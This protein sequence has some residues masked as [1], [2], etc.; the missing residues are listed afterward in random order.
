M[1][2]NEQF[3]W[4][5]VTTPSD[6]ETRRHCCCSNSHKDVPQVAVRNVSMVAFTR[7]KSL[8]SMT[9]P[10]RVS[11]L[12]L[13]L[14]HSEWPKLYGVLAVLSAIGLCT[15]GQTILSCLNM[16]MKLIAL[17]MA[18]TLW[19]FGCSECNRVMYCRISHTE[20]PEYV[21]IYYICKHIIY[22]CQ[23]MYI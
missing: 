5:E 21:Y 23:H 19:S 10:Y 22:C 18:E 6:Q 3:S 1:D 8:S 4:L 11:Y 12:S 9:P 13:T 2:Q 20:L 15:V 16:W 7:H 17:R 14:L